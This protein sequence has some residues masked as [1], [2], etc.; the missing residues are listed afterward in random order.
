M[1]SPDA[2]NS[3]PPSLR[4]LKGLVILLMIT[5]IVGVITVVG[6]LVTRMP[7]ASALPVL[8]GQITLPDGATV[9]AVTYGK[10][11][12]GVVTT[13]QRLLIFGQDGQLRQEVE[14]KSDPSP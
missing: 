4:F 1:N 13:D 11:W 12:F 5:M 9:Q 3:L 6:L 10:G 8:P 14:I 7:D 2:E